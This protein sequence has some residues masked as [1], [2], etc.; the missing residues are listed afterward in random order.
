MSV[1]NCLQLLELQM[2]PICDTFYRRCCK[3]SVISSQAYVLL[4]QYLEVADEHQQGRHVLDSVWRRAAQQRHG[5]PERAESVR[6][7]AAAGL[8]EE[9]QTGGRLM[10]GRGGGSGVDTCVG[11]ALIWACCFYVQQ[12]KCF[13]CSNPF[14]YSCTQS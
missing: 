12:E 11:T 3:S 13:N 9:G 4:F 7:R 2:A 1:A 14:S 10:S 6:R 8:H 5:Q